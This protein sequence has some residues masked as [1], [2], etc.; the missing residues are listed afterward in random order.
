MRPASLGI[1]P[2]RPEPWPSSVLA[3][4]DGAPGSVRQPRAHVRTAARCPPRDVA[5]CIAT[6]RRQ[7]AGSVVDAA[8]R[9]RTNCCMR[10]G[11]DD[12]LL[13]VAGE[14]VFYRRRRL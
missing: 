11:E 10:I 13:L 6:R 1:A 7:H 8:S 4:S 12:G 9:V 3:H 2:G 14:A 5:R